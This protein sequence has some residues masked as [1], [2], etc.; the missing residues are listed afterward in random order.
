MKL[1]MHQALGQY[2]VTGLPK[3]VSIMNIQFPT[4]YRHKT[5]HQ[6]LLLKYRALLQLTSGF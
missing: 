2:K 4:Y 1:Y 6:G 5:G 3:I